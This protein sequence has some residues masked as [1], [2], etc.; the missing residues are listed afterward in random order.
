MVVSPF[1][2]RIQFLVETMLLSGTLAR[3]AV[4]AAGVALV[5]VGLGL[6]AHV[7][8]G[9]RNPVVGDP[10]DAVWWAFLRLTDPGYLGDDEGAWLR[11]IST[12]LTLLGYVLFMGVLV[13]VLA[14]G[15]NERIKR[16][17]RGLSPISARNHI[18]L[19]GWSNRLPGIVHNLLLSEQRVKRFLRR[20]GAKRLRLVLLVEEVGP[21]HSAELR[22]HLGRNWRAGDIILRS[23]TALRLDNLQRVDYLRA[24]AIVL[25]AAD[26]GSGKTAAQSDDAA[27]KTLIGISH[28]MRLAAPDRAPPLLVAELYDARKIPVALHTYRGPVEVVAG[29]EVVSRMIAQMV[30]HPHI[31]RV[32]RELLTLVSGNEIFARDCPPEWAGT[33]FWA[34]AQ[35]W[36]EALLIGVT[37]PAAGGVRPLLVPEADEAL[38]A[39]DK[40]VYIAR[41]W[42][43]GRVDE[44]TLAAAKGAAAPGAR[45]WPTP[46]GRPGPRGG[47]RRRVLVL[48]WSRRVPALLAEFE[49]YAQ[50]EFEIVVG[51]RQPAGERQRVIAEYGQ[52]LSRMRV[53]QE[54]VD[55]TVP[56][57]L[58]ALEPMGFETVL[59]LASEVATSDEDA[60]ARSLVAHAVLR[61]LPGRE[62]SGQGGGRRPRVI[63]E[64][65]DELNVALLSPEECEQLVSSKILGHILV[66]VALRRELNAV[67]QELFNSGETE[68]GFRAPADYG[69]GVSG[70][71]GAGGDLTFAALQVRARAVGDV[72]LGVFKPGEVGTLTD[73]VYLNP[74]RA[75]RWQFGAV[76]RL[77]VLSR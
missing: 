8:A 11:V 45:R 36:D 41:D 24:A 60:D 56:E 13:A 3:L 31:G 68:I 77:I 21:E 47:A 64:L 14:Q 70:E 73:G 34:L 25:P 57:R 65:L 28:S 74:V 39:G 33:S 53:R 61:D 40:L 48:G 66:Q 44:E 38:Q 35:A 75:S 63:I 20:L 72:L 15:L 55:Y 58:A 26:R 71:G 1:R 67:F 6:L 23:G 27:I 10:L 76:D 37:R 29:D 2:N 54:E 16:L 17:E 32:Y 62:V 9:P 7:M 52:P 18:I 49:S 19:L 22:A 4:A 59:V 5:A 51:S 69:V 30:R 50:D 12:L 42:A 46:T 43:D